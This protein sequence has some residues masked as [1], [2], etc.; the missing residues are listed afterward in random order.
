MRTQIKK[1]S[2]KLA[3]PS[4]LA[5]LGPCMAQHRC[6]DW[7]TIGRQ[8]WPNPSVAHRLLLGPCMAAVLRPAFSRC[9]A[10]NHF[11]ATLG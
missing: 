7:P 11:Y 6:H 1:N 8:A 9:F 5:M 2:A 3:L 4:K 10:S